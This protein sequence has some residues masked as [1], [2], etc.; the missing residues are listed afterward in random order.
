MLSS[1]ACELADLG[2]E[3]GSR[4]VGVG[5]RPLRVRLGR[6]RVRV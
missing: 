1:S 6:A 5:S 2:M 4:T 3:L